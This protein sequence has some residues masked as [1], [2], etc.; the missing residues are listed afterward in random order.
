MI[1]LHI[2]SIKNNPFSGVAVVVPQHVRQQ[3]K[4]AVTTLLNINNIIINGIDS[5]ISFNAPF[6]ISKLPA[7]FSKPDIVIFHE[8]YRIRYLSVYKNLVKNGVPYIIIPHGELTIQ[9]QQKKWLKKKI[10][11][12]L[13]FNH[14]IKK[15]LA[16]QCLS[17]RESVYI[18]SRHNKFI[19]TNGVD[20]PQK[21]KKSFNQN[22]V[23]FIYIGRLEVY[24]KGLDLMLEAVRINHNFM[25]KNRCILDIYGPDIEGRLESLENLVHEK[26]IGDIVHLNSEVLGKE[27][28]EILLNA[29]IF[30]QTSRSEGMPLGILEALSYGI[31]CLVTEGT[32]L[33]IKIAKADAGWSSETDDKRIAEAMVIAVKDRQCWNMKSK[34]GYQLIE[35]MYNWNKIAL[36]TIKHYE[37]LINKS[38]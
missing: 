3:G 21:K 27:K 35:Q 25:I 19:G 36:D 6:D 2:A 31:P 14:F 22:I 30:I 37:Q 5:Q 7:P 24:S 10:A 1:I 4:Y 26:K 32:T 17:E 15:S 28:E 18:R 8:I 11:N 38:S 16:I 9:A 20:L 13:F 12:F 29:D 23:K 33:G 34:N